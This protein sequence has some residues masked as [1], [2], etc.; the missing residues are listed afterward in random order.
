MAK[1]REN[2]AFSVLPSSDLE[3]DIKFYTQVVGLRLHSVYPAVKPVV[4]ELIGLGVSL[5]LD[6]E[7]ADVQPGCLLIKSEDQQTQTQYSPSGTAVVWERIKNVAP[8]SFE[9]YRKEICTLRGSS[10]WVV[11]RAGTHTRD[12]IPSRL[13]GGIIASHIR[14]PNGGPVADRVHYHTTSFQLVFC[15]QGW[16]TLVY[17]DQGQPI[18]LKAGDCVTQPPH[19]RHRVMETSNGLELIEIGMPAEHITALDDDMKL[20]NQ[21]VDSHRLFDDQYFCHHKSANAHWMPHRLPGF[22]SSDSGTANASG[23][24]AGAKLLKATHAG[25]SYTTTHSADVLFSYVLSGSVRI[26][27]QLLVAGDAFTVPPDDPYKIG[28]ISSDVKI[29]EVSVPGVFETQIVE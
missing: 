12:L 27:K 17:E 29:L 18:T 28:D 21:R 19:I 25:Q 16:I 14:I 7:L 15:V 5:R 10:P 3:A 8:Q 13:G 11:G 24:L 23:N 1:K 22:L 2:Q 4:A 20:P 6:T 26:D 9:N